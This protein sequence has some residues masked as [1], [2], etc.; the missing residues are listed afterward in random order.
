MVSR[1]VF[2]ALALVSAAGEASVPSTALRGT[3]SL[4]E[5]PPAEDQSAEPDT[6]M[7]TP[8]NATEPTA[9]FQVIVD[10]MHRELHSE[11]WQWLVAVAAFC[12]GVAAVVF[13]KESFKHLTIA[14][15]FAVTYTMVMGDLHE[16]Y[17]DQQ[18]DGSITIN[19]AMLWQIIV[20]IEVAACASLVAWRGFEGVAQFIAMVIGIWPMKMLQAT[21]N[22]SGIFGASPWW[23]IIV[24]TISA[25]F[26]LFLVR[27]HNLKLLLSYIFPFIGGKLIS[28]SIGWLLWYLVDFT[29]SKPWLDFYHS[30]PF[31]ETVPALTPVLGIGWSTPTQIAGPPWIGSA[32]GTA[33]WLIIALSSSCFHHHSHKKQQKLE[34]DELAY[35]AMP[36]ENKQ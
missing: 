24:V 12:F 29:W 26:G 8:Q 2:F 31:D 15:V 10:M 23:N 25:V 11:H 28:C 33:I 34:S 36:E 21:L 18:L 20:S 19:G 13:P 7:L 32:G 35:K 4:A 14:L 5:E 30:L 22:E 27:K 16:R 3:D 9:A 1:A 17:K 6:D